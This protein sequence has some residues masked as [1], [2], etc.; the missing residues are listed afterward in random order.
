MD[1]GI[2]RGLYWE[3]VGCLNTMI[4]DEGEDR[5]SLIDQIRTDLDK[6]ACY[7]DNSEYVEAIEKLNQL[8]TIRTVEDICDELEDDLDE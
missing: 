8:L 3:A 7:W 6:N 4:E 1:E 2:Q 5:D